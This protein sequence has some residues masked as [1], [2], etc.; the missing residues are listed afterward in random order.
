M[1]DITVSV[2]STQELLNED[3]FSEIKWAFNYLNAL[4]QKGIVWNNREHTL[5]RN[6]LNEATKAMNVDL[7]E[8][9]GAHTISAK[10]WYSTIRN[11][12]QLKQDQIKV[13]S[14]QTVKLIHPN[15]QARKKAVMKWAD[16]IESK[17]VKLRALLFTVTDRQLKAKLNK[18]VNQYSKEQDEVLSL[19]DV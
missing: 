2:L 9:K 1:N 8:K 15:P 11:I 13:Q 14:R 12:Q 4:N 19:L 6:L 7:D 16:S 18:L 17:L 5:Y 3:N 10:E